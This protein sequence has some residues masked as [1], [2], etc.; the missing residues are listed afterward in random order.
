MFAPV[1]V[2]L[3][4]SYNPRAGKQSPSEEQRKKFDIIGAILSSGA[5]M[6]LA[7]AINFGGVVYPWRSGQ[8]IALFIVSL[9]LLIAFALQQTFC[10]FVD[11]SERMFPV[12][13]LSNMEADLLFIAAACGNAAMFIP[14]FYLPVYF[15]FSRGDSALE[16]AVRMLPFITLL[17]ATILSSGYLMGKLGYFQ[18]WY[19]VGAALALVGHV[20]LC[21]SYEAFLPPSMRNMKSLTSIP[22]ARQHHH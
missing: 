14:L 17:C 3:L 21:K 18:P 8:T 7:M 16:A 6:S 15:Q 22:S 4:P 5:I 11:E 1:Y 9:I 2:F 10:W 19:L 20:L 13:F 12:Q